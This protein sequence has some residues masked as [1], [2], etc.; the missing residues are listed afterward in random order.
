MANFFRHY[1]PNVVG[2]SLGR[3]VV[4][5]PEFVRSDPHSPVRSGAIISVVNALCPNVAI[6]GMLQPYY[7]QDQLNG[8]QSNA[9]VASLMYQL[10]YAPC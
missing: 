6:S 10:E 5:L 1:S 3:H 7:D 8:A 4:E 9:G 2:A